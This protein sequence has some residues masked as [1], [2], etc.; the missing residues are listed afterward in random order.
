MSGG[1][2]DYNQYRLAQIADSITVVV[3][4]NANTTVD[5]YGSRVGYG[6]TP[7]TIEIRY[8]NRNH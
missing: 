5:E 2:F 4:N 3:D 1:H 6:F 7:A 8:F